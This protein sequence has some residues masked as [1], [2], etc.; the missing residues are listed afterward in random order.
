MTLRTIN[1]T[2]IRS[3][4]YVVHKEKQFSSSSLLLNNRSACSLIYCRTLFKMESKKVFA[5]LFVTFCLCLTWA[6]LALLKY[7]GKIF[8]FK[9][10]SHRYVPKKEEQNNYMLLKK[11]EDMEKLPEYGS[12]MVWL[13]V[14]QLGT[15]AQ[16]SDSPIGS[17][18]HSSTNQ[19][20]NNKI[21][22]KAFPCVS[23]SNLPT[24]M[25]TVEYMGSS[26]GPSRHE[27]CDKDEEAILKGYCYMLTNLASKFEFCVFKEFFAVSKQSS[28][29]SSLRVSEFGRNHCTEISL[30]KSK[31]LIFTASNMDNFLYAKMFD[32]MPYWPLI[33]D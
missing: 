26:L 17:Y 24:D 32:F 14:Y 4:I 30:S 22:D 8:F 29:L 16:P 9:F 13:I 2:Q 33:H 20:G 10:P 19:K 5:V 25:E 21:D 15:H 18:Y 3:L 6:L 23:L 27:A 11:V 28:V 1:A 31:I 12:Q 7:G